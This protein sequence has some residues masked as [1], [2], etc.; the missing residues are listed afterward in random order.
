MTTPKPLT[1]TQ[2]AR[3]AGCSPNTI[4][5]MLGEGKLKGTRTPIGP[6]AYRWTLDMTRAE[7]AEATASLRHIRYPARRS[8]PVTTSA[9]A[10]TGRLAPFVQWVSLPED[11][12]ELLLKIWERFTAED[13]SLLCEM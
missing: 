10:T 11:K 8:K 7:V 13:L 9:P 5:R 1:P 2:A 3:I 12:R 6:H 4:T